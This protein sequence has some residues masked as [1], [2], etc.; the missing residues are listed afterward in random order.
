MRNANTHVKEKTLQTL[1]ILS[2]DERSHLIAQ[3]GPIGQLYM[4]K[5]DLGDLNARPNL[6]EEATTEA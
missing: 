2:L 6:S 3:N 1:L 5:C 4:C